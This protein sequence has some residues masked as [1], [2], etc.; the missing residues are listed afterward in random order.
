M[1]A[2]TP[3]HMIEFADVIGQIIKK[4]LIYVTAR[5][6]TMMSSDFC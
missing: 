1:I 5:S 4:R 6:Y 3:D 2:Y